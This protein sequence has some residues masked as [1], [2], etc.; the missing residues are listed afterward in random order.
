MKKNARIISI[1][2]EGKDFFIYFTGETYLDEDRY[3]RRIEREIVHYLDEDFN[4]FVM[5][6][7]RPFILKKYIHDK[8]SGPCN[9]VLGP[10]SP[11]IE[12]KDGVLVPNT[13]SYT[14]GL[15]EKPSMHELNKYREILAKQ[16]EEKYSS[17][18][19]M[20]R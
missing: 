1:S 3:G 12:N 9:Y 7:S 17:R 8:L 4:R 5:N 20:Y 19:H 15:W 6:G 11:E 13:S 10:H 16:I 14:I 2:N 18:Y